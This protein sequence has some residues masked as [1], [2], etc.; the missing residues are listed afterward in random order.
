MSSVIFWAI[1]L[2]ISISTSIYY[3]EQDKPTFWVC[4]TFFFLGWTAMGLF[5]DL[6][7]LLG[8]VS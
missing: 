7:N 8:L 4:W 5:N 1:L 6:G 2:V 3:V